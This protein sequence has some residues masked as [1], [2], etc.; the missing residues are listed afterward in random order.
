[1]RIGRDDQSI[2]AQETS[3]QL[4]LGLAHEVKNPLGGIRGAAQLLQRVLEKQL[5]EPQLLDSSAAQANKT[6][7]IRPVSL[8][9]LT[10]YTDV[11]INEADR[12][13]NLVDRMLG[14]NQTLELAPTNIHRVLSHVLNLVCAEFEIPLTIRRDYDP[15]LPD[16][17]AD[18]E[19]LVQALLNITR[20]ALQ[21]MTNTEEPTLTL[22]AWFCSWIS[23]TTVL[24]SRPRF[25]IVCFTP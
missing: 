16:L 4:V 13:G 7:Q 11:I 14:P 22:R 21:A 15:S 3:R 18:D 9:E 2:N 20:N 17:V 25:K 5:S 19:R 1:M 23:K 24:G 6:G 12:L 10:E 8:Q